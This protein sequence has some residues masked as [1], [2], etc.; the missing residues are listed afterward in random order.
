MPH[1]SNQTVSWDAVTGAESYNYTALYF[2][3]ELS[4]VGGHT[5]TSGSTTSTSFS[6]TTPAGGRYIHFK[7]EAVKGNDKKM[8]TL[9][10]MLGE[11]LSYP[12]DVEYIPI[13]SVNGNI[14]ESNSTILTSTYG[15]TFTREWWR[16]FECSPNTDGTY[17]VNKIYENGTEKSITV[18]GKTILFVMH[19]E[20]VNYYVARKI[21]VG[22][23]LTLKGIYLDNKIAVENAHLLVNGGKPVAP[24]E[25]TPKDNDIDLDGDYVE[26]ADAGITGDALAAKFN[27]DGDYI[28]V[29]D[30]SGKEV[31]S[32]KVGTG[33][34]VNLVVN[35]ETK[36]SYK[37][38]IGGDVDGDGEIS[39]NDHVAV[40]AHFKN[41]S[42][43]SEEYFKAADFT[44]NGKLT[45]TDYIS[46]KRK[47]TK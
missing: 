16:A 41:H 18:S 23:K 1:N 30:K 33:C 46:I 19:A 32:G 42:I 6:V 9:T 2:D 35:G 26:G 15:G 11:A 4:A 3:G 40:K 14:W 38:V 21:V 13:T 22:D 36:A 17:T 5:I 8:S 12:E 28:K 31:T 7:V 39:A 45:V 43:L 10:L 25:L 27:E 37:V 24:Q 29:L 34:T 20:Y 44:K 47:I